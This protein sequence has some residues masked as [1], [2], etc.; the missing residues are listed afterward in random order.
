[1]T[2]RVEEIGSDPLL[3]E[4]VRTARQLRQAH[5]N[6]GVEVVRHALA[7]RGGCAAG[8]IVPAA[9]ISHERAFRIAAGPR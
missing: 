9:G 3:L 5:E 1:M 2:M 6:A 8:E 4:G 7:G